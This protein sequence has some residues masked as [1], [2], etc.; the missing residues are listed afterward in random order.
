MGQKSIVELVGG[1]QETHGDGFSMKSESSAE[2]ASSGMG[3]WNADE[4]VV[5]KDKGYNI[6]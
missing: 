5:V 1:D 4:D 3:S 2:Y 6:P